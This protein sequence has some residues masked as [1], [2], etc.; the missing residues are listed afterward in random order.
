MLS[1]LYTLTHD[2]AGH[3]SAA[4]AAL[5]LGNV[6]VGGDFATVQQSFGVSWQSS[7][8]VA[9]SFSAGN[10]VPRDMSG[11]PGYISGKPVLAGTLETDAGSGKQAVAA[12]AAGLLLDDCTGNAAV[13]VTYGDA[14][15]FGCSVALT[16]AELEAMCTSKSQLD[17]FGFAPT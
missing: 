2:G 7:A 10:A 5:V 14:M 8:T 13:G 3:V 15:T 11:N 4:S 6:T 17:R 9:T 12:W 16:L 1:V